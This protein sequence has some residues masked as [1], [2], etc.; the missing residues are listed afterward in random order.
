MSL[1][2]DDK[3]GIAELMSQEVETRLLRAF[4]NLSTG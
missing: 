4:R 2:G 3:T 1:T